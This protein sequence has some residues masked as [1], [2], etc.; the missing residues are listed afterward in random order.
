[1]DVIK[2]HLGQQHDTDPAPAARPDRGNPDTENYHDGSRACVALLSVGLDAVRAEILSFYG[3]NAHR[4]VFRAGTWLEWKRAQR[5][6]NPNEPLNP[7]RDEGLTIGDL[8]DLAEEARLA[9]HRTWTVEQ[10]AETVADLRA[11]GY[12]DVRPQRDGSLLVV[13][14]P[15]SDPERARARAVPM[16]PVVR[17][18]FVSELEGGT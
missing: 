1:M 3:R 7:G 10:V 18:S 8:I 14:D 17:F 16:V 9:Y 4:R 11:R 5:E 13:V 12:R 15:A 2:M 6:F